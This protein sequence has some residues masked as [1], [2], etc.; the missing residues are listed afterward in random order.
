M[1]PTP[2]LRD[3]LSEPVGVGDHPWIVFFDGH[4]GLC[5]RFVNFVLKR[6]PNG[7]FRFSPLQGETA[8]RYL[9]PEEI[10]AVQSLVVATPQGLFRRSTGA[11][12]VLQQLGPLYN[13]TALVLRFIP[14]P[15]RDL[16]YDF[17]ARHRFKFFGRHDQCR[18]PTPAERE[19]FLP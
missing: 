14:S 19:R 18:L 5:D 9:S 12:R 16:A 17:I 1:N 3:P 2:P 7:I 11:L 6:D 15:L 4:C 13:I 10:Q 8:A